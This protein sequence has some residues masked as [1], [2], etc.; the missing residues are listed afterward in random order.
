MRIHLLLTAVVI[1]LLGPRGPVSAQQ[2]DPATLKNEIEIFSD[3]VQE[4]LGLADGS[5]FLGIGSGRVHGYYLRGQGVVLEVRSPLANQRNRL[6]LSALAASL[7]NV[8]GRGNLADRLPVQPPAQAGDPQPVGVDAVTRADQTTEPLASS[9]DYRVEVDAALGEAN[10]IMRMLRDLGAMEPN[11]LVATEQSLASLRREF[12]ETLDK[13]RQL[14]VDPGTRDGS[15]SIPGLQQLQEK[16]VALSNGARQQVASLDAS[17]ETARENLR[18]RWLED[19]AELE[20]SLYGLLCEFGATL[21]SVR[22]DEQVSIIL[23]GLGSQG[24]D[25]GVSDRI[26]IISRRDIEACLAGELDEVA[27]HRRAVSYDY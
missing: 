12:E 6:S 13:L 11:A 25:T 16:L 5:G 8:A 3:I 22:A 15:S 7:R 20:D 10:R 19:V 4:G 26:H 18:Q 14:E 27:L 17:F 1:S 9:N 23:T 2:P 21:N 24:A